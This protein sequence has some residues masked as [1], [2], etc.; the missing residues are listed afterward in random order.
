MF[1][2]SPVDR[3]LGCFYFL[4]IM[5]N[6]AMNIHVQVFAS[7]YVF[8][9]LGYIPRSGISGS[10]GK[11]MFNLLRNCKTLFKAAITVY[12]STSNM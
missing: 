6:V 10:Y 7:M 9:F 1:I 3:N 2:H 12:I 8:N 4:A 5:K 11:V